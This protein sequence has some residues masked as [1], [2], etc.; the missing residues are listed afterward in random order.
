M[1]Q[2][3]GILDTREYSICRVMTKH[4]L[5]CITDSVDHITVCTVQKIF[6]YCTFEMTPKHYHTRVCLCVCVCVCACLLSY[7][8]VRLR[9]PP[10]YTIYVCVC[11]CVIVIV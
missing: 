9:W 2:S 5:H 10:D 4:T 1:Y 6:Y 7:N 8:D 3:L 11:V